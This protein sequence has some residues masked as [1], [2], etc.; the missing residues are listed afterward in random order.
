MT[1]VPKI[2][3]LIDDDQDDQEIFT[4]ALKETELPVTCVVAH[5][6]SEA[7]KKLSRGSAFIPDYIFI[8]LNMPRINGKECLR[9]IRKQAHLKHVPIVMYSTSLNQRDIA[10][11]RQ[12][13][14]TTYI[15]K[16]SKISELASILNMFFSTVS[17]SMISN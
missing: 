10:E 12:I 16:P 9:E 11:T 5:D 4:M 2:C 1:G 7:L 14:A 17:P 3:F 6:C 15:I 8:D 13:G